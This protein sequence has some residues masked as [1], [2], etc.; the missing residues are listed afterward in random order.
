MKLNLALRYTQDIKLS[1]FPV[2]TN[3]L[4]DVSRLPEMEGKKSWKPYQTKIATREEVFNWFG[5]NYELDLPM[6]VVTG[7]LSNITVI[8]IDTKDRKSVG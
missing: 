3:K 5:N 2:L 4:P 8:D 6:A 1:I 7:K